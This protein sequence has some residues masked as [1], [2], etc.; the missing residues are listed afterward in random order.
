MPRGSETSQNCATMTGCPDFLREVGRQLPSPNSQTTS[1]TTTVL[2]SK[3]A[4]GLMPRHTRRGENH[5][6]RIITRLTYSD[7]LRFRGQV[8]DL[9]QLNLPQLKVKPNTRHQEPMRKNGR[10]V[11]AMA[12]WGALTKV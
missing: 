9:T 3:R 10:S 5:K 12:S 11:P 2:V 8:L 7:S 4:G 1:P 6:P